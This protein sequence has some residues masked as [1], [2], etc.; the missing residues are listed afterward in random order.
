MREHRSCVRTNG[1]QVEV[2][3]DPDNAEDFFLSKY[4]M[5][6]SYALHL[7]TLQLVYQVNYLGEYLVHWLISIVPAR[8]L[9]L[10]ARMDSD[11]C[12][13]NPSTLVSAIIDNC[14]SRNRHTCLRRTPCRSTLYCSLHPSP[15]RRAS[16]A[17]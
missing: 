9:F 16:C 8:N 14:C 17:P 6:N 10:Y 12:V 7:Q 4:R 5:R 3:R 13:E 11:Q 2:K 1:P 15:S